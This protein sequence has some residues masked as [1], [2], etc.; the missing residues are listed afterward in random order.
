MHKLFWGV[1]AWC[2]LLLIPSAALAQH[3]HDH[4]HGEGNLVIV[5]EANPVTIEFSSDLWNLVGFETVP[6]TEAQK[7]LLSETRATLENG[8]NILAFNRQAECVLQS[9]ESNFAALFEE[10]N[11]KDHEDHDSH[12]DH[13]LSGDHDDGH[14][15]TKV[16]YTFQCGRLDR[17]NS[18]S[19]S[20]LD[21]FGN[22]EKIEA[23]AF[24]S[25]GQLWHQF[26]KNASKMDL[27]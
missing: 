11:H 8:E 4:V 23:V 2:S 13:G 12:Q 26:R 3:S 21:Q 6:E 15:K 7:N 17:L 24:T 16:T 9:A 22:L 19:T 5:T 14:V 20:L 1:V 25:S 27:K 10:H 18:L